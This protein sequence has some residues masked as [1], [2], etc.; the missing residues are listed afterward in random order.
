MPNVN[1]QSYAFTALTPILS[2][3]TEGVVHAAELRSV[4]ARLTDA[5]TEPF[6][7]VPG[8]HFARWT[9][10]D[11][12]PQFGY[13]THPDP[14]QSKYLMLETDFDGDRDAWIAA[15]CTA[16]PDVLRD[17]YSHCVGYPG[18][19]DAGAFQRYLVSCQLDTTLNFSPFVSNSLPSVL[20]A[21]DAQRRFVG[22]AREVQGRSNLELRVAFT[23]FARQLRSAPVR[24]PGS[25]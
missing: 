25:I 5:G 12:V 11:D 7:R 8:T 18:L 16:M 2:G 10:I 1:E 14:L 6:A 19:R 22:F 3:R 21:L 23:E 13:P 17:V 20:R 9:I 4:L 24:R 15:L